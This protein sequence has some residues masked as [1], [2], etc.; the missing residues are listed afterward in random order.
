MSQDSHSSASVPQED[1]S[2]NGQHPSELGTFNPP[3]PP[4]PQGTVSDI[5]AKVQHA[6]HIQQAIEDLR[7]HQ[8]PDTRP[9]PLLEH[10]QVQGRDLHGRVTTE[11]VR[12][13]GRLT[14][15]TCTV[16][17]LINGVFA[18]PFF[19]A[20]SG[21]ITGIIVTSGV[22]L[23]SNLCQKAA[24]RLPDARDFWT[25]VGFR[26]AVA[27]G[28]FLTVLSPHGSMLLLFR[29]DLNQQ[30]AEKIVSEFVFADV[31]GELEAAE[32][33]QDLAN[34]KQRLC[35]ELL[36]EYATRKQA[37]D[38]SYHIYYRRAL[39][40]YEAEVSPG[41][42]DHLPPAQRP[43]C[44]AA[45]QYQL[46]A[47]NAQVAAQEAQRDRLAEIKTE[48]GEDFLGFL[49]ED[50]P[51]LYDGY[52]TRDLF[53]PRIRSGITELGQANQL[54]ISGEAAPLIVMVIITSLSAII[55]WVALALIYHYARH[56]QVS[57]SWKVWPL[58]RQEQ[59]LNAL[60]RKLRGQ[61]VDHE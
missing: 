36:R 38:L 10:A 4:Q 29:S 12:A 37:N 19:C 32:E 58:F 25:R 9:H 52:Y 6:P 11:E 39:G 43:A 44:Y 35:D 60:A 40:P 1:N 48:W 20:I 24:V 33:K 50:E 46:E 47:E 21:P 51:T 30:L 56:P 2:Q 54:L 18:A 13:R 16:S 55:T 7:D 42:Y 14:A 3:P 61:E 26:G 53:G 8:P 15:A 5:L 17:N 28:V 27:A 49:R 59:W 34:D 23:F 31:Q 41:R 45:Q 57:Q 22:Y